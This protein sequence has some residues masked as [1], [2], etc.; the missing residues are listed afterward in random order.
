MKSKHV[1]GSLSEAERLMVCKTDHI[2]IWCDG[3]HKFWLTFSHW[4]V[5]W[6]FRMD[7]PVVDHNS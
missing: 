2:D 1:T 7:K 5:L 6:Y 4:A 3:D